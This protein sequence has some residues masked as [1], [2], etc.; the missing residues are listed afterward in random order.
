V[1]VREEPSANEAVRKEV[2]KRIRARR[3]FLKLERPREFSQAGLGRKLSS[4][5]GGIVQGTQVGLWE[6]GVYIPER[7]LWPQLA[8]AL[9]TTV[10]TLFAG[11]L[12]EQPGETLADRV[13]RIE[14]QLGALIHLL[15]MGPAVGE[16]IAQTNA[17]ANRRA[18]SESAGDSAEARDAQEIERL[19]EEADR[20]E[21]E[22][23]QL[24]GRECET[25]DPPSSREHRTTGS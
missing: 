16:Q 4:R 25:G 2:G 3:E 7:R 11:L 13:S 20:S 23:E 14:D 21:Q 18:I 6:R 17:A 19:A 9:E 15:G 24:D 1:S 5:D 12:V 8:E 10:D 22:R